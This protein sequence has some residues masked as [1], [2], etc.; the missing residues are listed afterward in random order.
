MMAYKLANATIQN[1]LHTAWVGVLASLKRI[2]TLSQV[3]P[4]TASDIFREDRNASESKFDVGP[5]VFYL[6]EKAAHHSADLYVAIS[7]WITFGETVISGEKRRVAIRFGTQVGYFKVKSQ[8]LVQVYGVHYD[9][10]DSLPGHP[11]FHAQ[12]STQ[13]H[14]GDAVRNHFNLNYE[15]GTDRTQGLLGNVRT[16]TAQMDAFSVFTQL[17]A[18]HLTSVEVGPT[19]RDAFN[20]LRR[21]CSYF[22]GAGAEL[23]YLNSLPATHC[24]RSTHWY[25]G[26][27]SWKTT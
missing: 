19:V 5:I 13:A 18:D 20:D 8:T 1:E 10:D 17:A 16:P 21:A 6:P 24:Y 26:D 3:K 7:G 9:M 27:R 23:A 22:V 15:D 25:E 2:S 14:L 12:M 11:V 4:E